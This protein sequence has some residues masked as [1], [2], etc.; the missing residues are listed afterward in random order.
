MSHH[1]D[2]TPRFHFTHQTGINSETLVWYNF[3][4]LHT[5]NVATLDALDT[6]GIASITVAAFI[7]Q[8]VEAAAH[9]EVKS[10]SSINVNRTSVS[11]LW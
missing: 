9:G 7:S 4:P 8:W 10:A 2:N 11:Q 5:Y 3:T 1:H 6:N